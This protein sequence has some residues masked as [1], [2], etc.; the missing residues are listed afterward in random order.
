MLA[1]VLADALVEKFG[2]DSAGDL[3]AAVERYRTRLHPI[4]QRT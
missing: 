4:D 2:C 3:V 1:F